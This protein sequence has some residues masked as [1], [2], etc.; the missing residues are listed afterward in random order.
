MRRPA[1][2][3]RARA[4]ASLVALLA[5]ALTLPFATSRAA[6]E[7]APPATATA[8]TAPAATTPSTTST[9]TTT[10]TNPPTT[11]TTTATTAPTPSADLA[12]TATAATPAVRGSAFSWALTTTNRGPS[13]AE[14]VTLTDK[15]AV[16]AADPIVSTAS[17]AGTCTPT[18]TDAVSCDLG[19]LRS[20]ASVQTTITQRVGNA[21]AAPLTSAGSVLSTVPDPSLGNNSVSSSADPAPAPSPQP[22]DTTPLPPAAEHAAAEPAVAPEVID[23]ADL[24][25]SLAADHTLV[26]TGTNVTFTVTLT[27]GG[28][29]PATGVTVQDA[30]PAGLTFVSATPSLGTYDSSTGN[31]TVGTVANGATET[32]AIT[33]TGT[34]DGVTTDTAAISASGSTDPNPANNLASSSIL[35]VTPRVGT[36]EPADVGITKT[37]N[38][39]IP[40]VGSAIVFTIVMTNHGPNH[41]TGTAAQDTLPAGLTFVSSSGDGNYDVNTG[42]WDGD[43]NM[44][45]GQSHTLVITALVSAP[46]CFANTAQVI[47]GA[48]PDPNPFNNTATVAFCSV[49]PLQHADLA[50]TKTASTTQ[51]NVGDD[52]TFTVTLSNLGPD[53][54]T[55]VTA[56]DALPTGMDFVSATPSQGSYDPTDGV[57]TVGSVPNGAAVTLVLVGT[58]TTFTTL[59]NTASVATLEQVDPDLTNNTASVTLTPQQADVAVGKTVSN[60]TPNVGG[61]VSFTVIAGNIGPNAATNVTVTDQIPAGVTLVSAT[62]SQGTFVPG[63][64]LWTIGTLAAGSAQTLTITVVATSPDTT[65]NTAIVSHSDQFDP[66]PSNNTASASFT[67]QQ[68]D[69]VIGK[70]V[71]DPTPNVGD[72]VTFTITLGNNGPDLATNVTVDDVLP[73]GFTL[74]SSTPSQGTYDPGTGVW[75]VGTVT[76]GSPQTLLITAT[77]ASP[78]PQTNTAT[79]GASDQFDPDTTN[80]AAAATV[81]PQQADLIVA[82]Q[83]SDP[84]PNVG[85]TISYHIEVFNAGPDD[86]TNVTVQDTLPA[87]LS[88]VSSTPSAG[89]YD[90]TSGTWTIGTIP[91]SQLETLVIQALVVS[92]SPTANTASISHADQFDPNTANNSDTASVNPLEADLALSKTVSDA[93]PNVGDQVTFSITLDNNGP[94]N[95]TTVSVTDALPAGLTFVSSTPSQGT[96]N[97]GSGLWTVGTVADG[98]SA[99]LTLVATVNSPAAQT[100]TASITS[101]DQSDPDLG[102]N[103]ASATVTPQQ[104]DLAVSKLSSDP[105]PNVGQTIDFT[106]TLG[107]LGPNAATDVALTDNLPAG[108]T[109]VSATATQGAYSPATGIWLIGSVP[110]STQPTLTLVA[111]VA[112]PNA[113]TNTA[114]ISHSDQLDPDTSNNSATVTVTPQQADLAVTKVVSQVAPTVGQSITFDVTVT[115][116]GPDDATKVV[117]SDPLPPGLVFQ[118]AF[119]DQGTYDP[120]T[121][122]WTVGT[123]PDG[124]SSTLTITAQVT[125]AVATNTASVAH[126]DQFDPDTTNN[127][128]SVTVDP[129]SADLAISKTADNSRPAT[130]SAVVFTVTVANHGPDAATN[131]TVLDNLPA[132]LDFISATPSQGT[133]DPPAGLWTVGTLAP[134]TTAVLQITARFDGG[135]RTNIAR[136]GHS[137]QFDPDAANNTASSTV[138]AS[139]GPPT[140]GPPVVPESEV[141]GASATRL[142]PAASQLAPSSGTSTGLAFSGGDSLPTGIVGLLMLVLGT[143]LEVATRRR[144]RRVLG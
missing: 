79:V 129:Q 65:V 80:N 100:N 63:T 13:D 81:T 11:S 125:V 128:A 86:A 101:A 124:T 73:A 29:D 52:V 27:N 9:T 38:N 14:N 34:N 92:P 87:Q 31:W 96:Y 113:Q 33:A 142:A 89:T 1:P 132:G 119:P 144:R 111:K 115:N 3:R 12:L 118:S 112:S 103:T 60:A 95:A 85:D 59:T 67:P 6:A 83:V 70:T 39:P 105:T 99:T 16:D 127:T 131:V 141:L 51:P 135:T 84:T 140:P 137:D 46:G 134:S 19:T 42:K 26:E 30:L 15:L 123:L 68:A 28:P 107:N 49:T 90:S 74:V 56:V 10:T 23:P 44:A 77:V 17:S 43:L 20:G 133:Y 35:V 143:I 18:S 2:A 139:I 41:S 120:A 7:E 75:T 22:V 126:S 47:H 122:V 121:G 5:V 106:I 54:A 71:S 82:K 110:T 69:L 24:G 78:S 37:V 64:G 45:N 97:S 21:R 61:T 130:G 138:G 76:P 102:N 108:L 50:V 98:A 32:L 62:P 109:F 4:R 55:N 36:P 114:T 40:T 93:T 91:S 136:I 25:V 48:E 58:V 116:N 94:S 72:T 8:Q 57:W 117:V 53:D 66:D 104:A 88:F